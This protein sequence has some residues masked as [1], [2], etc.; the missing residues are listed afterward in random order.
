MNAVANTQNTAHRTRQAAL[1]RKLEDL[2]G[3][4]IQRDELKIETA[5]DAL[6]QVIS[7]TNRELAVTQLEVRTRLL[8]DVL[9]SLA[10]LEQ[11]TY[12]FCE[13][14]EE[15]IPAK[16]LDAVPWAHLCVRRQER[17]E[18]RVSQEE[19]SIGIAA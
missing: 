19:M 5:A 9:A 7:S 14:C 8:R 6:D 17:A 11:G 4:S 12:G 10:K 13:D 3:S 2:A 16:R 15:P 1:R 18:A